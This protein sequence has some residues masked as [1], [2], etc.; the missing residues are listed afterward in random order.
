[1]Q[2]FK[3]TMALCLTQLLCWQMC[4]A[5]VDPWERINVVAEGKKVA[6]KILLGKTVNGK[7]VAWTPDSLTVTQR[8]DKTVQLAR[9]DVAQVL[10]VTGKSRGERAGWAFLAGGGVGGAVLAAAMRSE[11]S[12]AGF[13]LAGLLWF[14]GVAAGIAA[15]F[16][17]HKELIYSA[18]P[19]AKPW[20]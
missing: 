16:P 6:V 15:L 10:L 17:A 20:N 5:Q 19:A 12:A 7:V 18:T 3:S 14:G 4:L 11:G 13:F 8:N 2:F 1:M 9:S